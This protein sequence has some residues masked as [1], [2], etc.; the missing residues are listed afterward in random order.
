MSLVNCHECGKEES[1][2]TEKCPNC[3]A[4][5]KSEENNFK[6]NFD[7]GYSLLGV[8]LCLAIVFSTLY[9]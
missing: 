4:R 1:T 2:S 7:M 5:M 3:G 6:A 9:R 8:V